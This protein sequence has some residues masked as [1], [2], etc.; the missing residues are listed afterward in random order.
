MLPY[1]IFFLQR[2]LGGGGSKSTDEDDDILDEEETHGLLGGQAE[3]LP[4]SA[5]RDVCWQ[6]LFL[7]SFLFLHFCL[8]PPNR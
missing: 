8:L 4:M 7:V 6:N 3:G 1:I 5:D 2:G